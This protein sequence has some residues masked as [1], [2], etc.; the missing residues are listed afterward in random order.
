MVY[1]MPLN[2]T[3]NSSTLKSNTIGLSEL[4]SLKPAPSISESNSEIEESFFSRKSV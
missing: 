2:F 1:K 4:P 3:F